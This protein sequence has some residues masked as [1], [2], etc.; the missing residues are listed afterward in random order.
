MHSEPLHYAI[1]TTGSTGDIYPFMRIALSLQAIGK[2][3][4]FITHVVHAKLLH[5]SGLTFVGF[6]SEEEYLRVINNPDIWHPRR[7]VSVLFADCKDQF[8]ELDAVIRSTVANDSA[9]VITHP[10]IVPSLAIA[11]DRGQIFNIV[12]MHLAPSGLRTCYDPLRIGEITIPKWV[13]MS[14]RKAYWRFVE[15]GWIDPVALTQTNSARMA[16]GLPVIHSSFLDHIEQVPDLTVTLFPTWFGSI[17]PDWPQPMI[18][19]DFQLFDS[20]PGESFSHELQEFIATGEKPLVFTPGTANLHAS[21]FFSCALA[22]IKN[23]GQ[24]AILLTKDR[25]QLPDDLP[26]SVLWQPYVPLVDLLPRVKALV[27]HG[28]IGTTA[29][30]FRAATPQ[31]VI[32]FAWDQFDNAARVEELGV[33]VVLRASRINPRRFTSSIRALINSQEVQSRC[34][35]ISRHFN[36]RVDPGELCREIEAALFNLGSE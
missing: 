17:M 27:H 36:K 25:S 14:W 7:A 12:S 2:K 8:L 21:K 34:N 4:T 24:R 22:A 23:L 11:R 33:G 31:L 30:A 18:N 32:P 16:L 10:L 20:A 15:K 5:G 9:V 19:A 1:I 26:D 29:E 3:V 6:G 13:P 35:E 28:G